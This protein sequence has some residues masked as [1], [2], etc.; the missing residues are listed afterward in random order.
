MTAK[1]E[2]DMDIIT[3]INK[4]DIGNID[5]ENSIEI[6]ENI[7]EGGGNNDAN[8]LEMARI[9]QENNHYEHI[10]SNSA[11]IDKKVGKRTL[12]ICIILVCV[13]LVYSVI[14]STIALI[15]ALKNG[16]STQSLCDCTLNSLAQN[17]AAESVANST[18][19]DIL[20]YCMDTKVSDNP[21]IGLTV[22]PTDVPS[23]NPSNNPTIKPSQAPSMQ[24]IQPT[25]FPSLNPSNSPSMQ[26]TYFD[27]Y[28]IGDFKFSLKNS[29]HGFW[30]LC[31]GDLLQINGI[32]QSLFNE[33]GFSFG[34]YNDTN[35]NVTYFQLPNVSNSV[36][37]V[38]GT[39]HLIG[40]YIGS[41]TI[42]LTDIE[43]PSHRHFTNAG[44]QCTSSE[45]SGE[46]SVARYCPSNTP[47]AETYRLGGHTAT[48][49]TGPS[50]FSGSGGAFSLMQ[51]TVFI[52]NLFIH[53]GVAL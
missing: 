36:L 51:P 52:G 43:L 45:V 44:G 21:S 24:V 25:M 7:T 28:F 10:Q 32:Y 46:Q 1:S 12:I 50:S 3:E 17:T 37:G 53:S 14:I 11:N 38:A 18:F 40:D 16:S 23:N 39:N 35:L 26:P 15:I 49:N 42:T 5:T 34:I 31:N 9:N 48:A 20:G 4:T 19:C 41:E 6:D 13:L 8:N 33:I 2:K 27:G 30:K 22:I 29:D 47:T